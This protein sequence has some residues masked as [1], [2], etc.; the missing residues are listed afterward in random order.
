MRCQ[1]CLSEKAVQSPELAFWELPDGSRA[2][3]IQEVP[4]IKCSSCH[5]IYIDD[6][7]VAEIENQLLFIDT[8]KL[9]KVVSYDELMNMPKLL[10]KNYFCF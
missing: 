7:H 10:K 6:K 9:A 8:T 1:W 5:I 3:E 2:I 4:S